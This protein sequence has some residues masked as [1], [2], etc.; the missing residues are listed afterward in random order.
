MNY[1]QSCGA[2]IHDNNIHCAVCINHPKE[3]ELNMLLTKKMRLYAA[4]VSTMN[5]EL[6]YD[7]WRKTANDFSITIRNQMKLLIRQH[8]FKKKQSQLK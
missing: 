4:H 3:N 7:Q 8:D 6:N 2:I 1:C 5:K